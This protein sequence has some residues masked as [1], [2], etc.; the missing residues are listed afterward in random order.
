VVL[1]PHEVVVVRPPK[2]CPFSPPDTFWRL[3]KTLYGLRRSPRHWYTCFRDVLL[4]MGLTPCP[5][6]PCLFTGI[7]IVGSPPLYLGI[8]VDDFAYFSVS[9]DVE[10]CCPTSRR[11]SWPSFLVPWNFIRLVSHSPQSP[12]RPSFA[13][14][15]PP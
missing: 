9:S 4:G 6:E 14:G 1:P 12:H 11:F 3:N 15:I 8:Y 5:H 7:L 13:G 10:P 2:G